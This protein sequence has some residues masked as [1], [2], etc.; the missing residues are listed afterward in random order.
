MN[1]F[2]QMDI[3]FVIAAIG[4]VVLAILAAIIMMYVI[5]L[6]RTLNRVA[7]N[8]EEEAQSLKEDLDAARASV[9]RGGV[10]LLSLFGFAG[11]AGTRLMK[12]KRASSSK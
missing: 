4:F 12:K 9:K 11:K 8:V 10:G 3:F 7:L 1:P 2:I 6:L 5:T